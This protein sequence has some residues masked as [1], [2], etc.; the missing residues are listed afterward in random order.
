MVISFSPGIAQGCFDLL[1]MA[2]R[3]PLSFAQIPSVFARLGGL[4]SGR[5][6]ET[7]QALNWLSAG[8]DG[9]AILT[10]PGA[11]ILSL[12]GYEPRLRR[13]LLDYIDAVRPPWVQNATFGRSRVLSFAGSEIAQVFVEAGLA[14]G[15][16]K[17]VVAFWDAMSARARGQKNIRL[18]EIGRDGERLTLAHEQDR[19]GRM[20][21]WVSIDNNEDGYDVLSVAGPTDI[22]QL[23]IEVKATNIGLAGSFHLTANEWDRA[24]TFPN[25]IFHLWNISGKVPSLAVLSIEDVE[26]HVPVNQGSGRWEYVEIP[27]GVFSKK[28][29]PQEEMQRFTHE[30]DCVIAL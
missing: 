27:F 3:M 1:E 5:V 19:T 15:T 29:L 26:P 23:S 9:I 16:E 8:E 22:S 6:V 21:K 30:A 17:E 4:P 18:T 12:A 14:H 10:P 11:K 7:V 2:D 25:H 13:A 28:L 20:P 24:L